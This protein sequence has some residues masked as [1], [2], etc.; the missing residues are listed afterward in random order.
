MIFFS[1][2]AQEIFSL[3][4]AQQLGIFSLRGAR[5][6]TRIF[7]FQGPRR[8]A[9]GGQK[10]PRGHFFWFLCNPPPAGGFS[11]PR[12]PGGRLINGFSGDFTHQILD[13]FWESFKQKRAIYLILGG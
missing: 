12:G 2:S 10:T 1:L 9:P 13:V 7:I 11:P 3:S 6:T 4:P 5:R 8:P